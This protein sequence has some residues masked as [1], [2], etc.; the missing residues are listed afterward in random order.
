MLCD[1]M[2]II[3][4]IILNVFATDAAPGRKI[5]QFYIIQFLFTNN[6]SLNIFATDAATVGSGQLTEVA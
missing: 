3:H 6:I 1:Y 5:L 2:H 4:D